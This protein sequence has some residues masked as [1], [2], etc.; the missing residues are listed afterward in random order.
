MGEQQLPAHWIT[1]HPYK[2]GTDEVILRRSDIPDW[3][4]IGDFTAQGPAMDAEVPAVAADYG[5]PVEA[6]RA[7][8]AYYRRH[9]AVIDNRLAANLAEA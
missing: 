9:Q 2:A 6:V 3:A 1:P 7:A 5:V 8:L 4:I